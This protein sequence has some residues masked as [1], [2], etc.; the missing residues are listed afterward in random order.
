M[1][2]GFTMPHITM[3]GICQSI[4]VMEFIWRCCCKIIKTLWVSWML[5]FCIILGCV[6]FYML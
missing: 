4:M 1:H 5:L 3:Y 6:G 2:F